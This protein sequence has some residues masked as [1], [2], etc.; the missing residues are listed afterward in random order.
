MPA[1]ALPSITVSPPKSSACTKRAVALDA[2]IGDERHPAV[3]CGPALDERLHLRHAEVRVEPRGAAAARPDADLDAVDAA[4]QRG[5]ARP[6]RWRRCRRSS[7]T[8]PNRLRNA[9]MARA[10]TTEWPCAMSMTMHVD[11]G[12]DQLR[13]ALEVIALGADRRADPQPALCVARR[14]RQLALRERSFAV[15][16]PSSV[17]SAST[18]GSFLILCVRIS[19]SAVRRDPDR[20]CATTSRSRGVMRDGDGAVPCPRTAGRAWSAGPARGALR[21]RRPACRRRCAASAPPLRPGVAAAPNGVR[22]VDDAVLLALDDL[23]LAHLRLDLAA[24]EAAVDDADAAF[25]GDGDRHLG[26]RDRVHVG[27]DDRPLQREVLGEARR[28]VDGRRIA[29]LD[30]AV[31]GREEEVVERAAA[32]EIETDRS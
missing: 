9:S 32:D 16:R 28:Q 18:S 5:S 29:A 22:V 30:D 15:I 27:R 19:S 21:R 14:E 12:A 8:S 10:M 26:A 20:R 13:G 1:S 24:A 11:P 2:A 4:L 7:S 23:D 3:G 6:R 25:F 17:P 31:L